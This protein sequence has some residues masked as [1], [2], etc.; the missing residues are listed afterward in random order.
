MFSHFDKIRVW[1]EKPLKGKKKM[2]DVRTILQQ[3]IVKG[4]G[5][6]TGF[7]KKI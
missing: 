3:E 4:V 6:D 7:E 2:R 1:K 5:I